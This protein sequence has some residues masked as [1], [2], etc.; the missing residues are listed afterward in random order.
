MIRLVLEPNGFI[1]TTHESASMDDNLMARYIDEIWM[2][3]VNRMTRSESI[4]TLND[5]P[6]H[7]SNSSVSRLHSNNVHTSVIPRGC[8]AV[9]QPLDVCLSKSFQGILKA[10]CQQYILL[11]TKNLEQNGKKRVTRPSRQLIVNWIEAAWNAIKTKQD[12][13]KKSFIVAGIGNSL[14]E[15]NDSVTRNG[16]Q[17]EIEKEMGEMNQLAVQDSA[18]TFADVPDNASSSDNTDFE[19][20]EMIIIDPSTFPDFSGDDFTDSTTVTHC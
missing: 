4:L 12:L 10:Y 5:F 16:L 17:E 2:P 13:I 6:A 18:N 1:V 9:V 20:Q 14:G 19:S 3:H 7:V 15:W 11:E 8:S